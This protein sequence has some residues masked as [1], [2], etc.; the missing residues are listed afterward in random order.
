MEGDV[1]DG[2]SKALDRVQRGRGDLLGSLGVPQL[3]RGRRARRITATYG[4]DN[5]AYR[6]GRG[7]A[8]ATCLEVGPSIT[9]MLKGVPLALRH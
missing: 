3:R 2:R 1:D 6:M 5:W 8:T 4:G 7:P 9:P